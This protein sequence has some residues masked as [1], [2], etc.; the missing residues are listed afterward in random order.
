MRVTEVHG[1]V[2]GSHDGLSPDK[3]ARRI[4]SHLIDGLGN[5]ILGGPHEP[6]TTQVLASDLAAVL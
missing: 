1:R 4:G 3:G 2:N 6:P 5:M